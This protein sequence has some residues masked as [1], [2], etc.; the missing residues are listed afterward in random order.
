MTEDYKIKLE[1]K[2]IEVEIIEDKDE[3]LSQVIDVLV[4]NEKTLKGTIIKINEDQ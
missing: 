4:K 2:K 1:E 3:K